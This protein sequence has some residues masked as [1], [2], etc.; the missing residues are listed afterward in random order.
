M[1]K[2]YYR[3]YYDRALI[4]VEG[5]SGYAQSG[6][7]IVCAGVSTLVF[8]FVNCI[9]DE[10]SN[11]RLKLIRNIV[12]DSYVCFEIEKFDFSK[13]RISG[14]VDAFITGFLMLAETYPQCVKLE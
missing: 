2:I 13:E 8:A 12:R 3:E 4:T 11:G 5:H 14:I 10:E 6:S 7:D 1:T 9:L